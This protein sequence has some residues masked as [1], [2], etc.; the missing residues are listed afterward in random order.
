MDNRDVLVRL[1]PIGEDRG[2][3]HRTVLEHLVPSQVSHM[4]LPVLAEVVYQDMTFIVLP[5]MWT[6]FT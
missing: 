4:P 2:E 5:L 3:T 1:M 6:S